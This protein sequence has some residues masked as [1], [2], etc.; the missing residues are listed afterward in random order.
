AQGVGLLP[1]AKRAE[2]G[3]V[4]VFEDSEDAIKA[5]EEFLGGGYVVLAEFAFVDRDVGFTNEVVG[6]GE[7]LRGVEVVGEAGVE[8]GAGFGDA[9]GHS[10]LA[11][12]REFSLREAVGEIAEAVNGAGG[13]L[14][15]VEGEIELAAVRDACQG[16]AQR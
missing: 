9:L 16:E 5:S 8:I 14:Q 4:I 15:A 12:G 11:A 10:R 6:G 2:F 1:I 3:G 13:F 7:G